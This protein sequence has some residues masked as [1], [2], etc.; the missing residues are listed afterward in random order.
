MISTLVKGLLAAVA[1][2]WLA[3]GL[4]A[5]NRNSALGWAAGR[6]ESA[7]SQVGDVRPPN[8]SPSSNATGAPT[9]VAGTATPAHAKELARLV[10]AT[11]N[12]ASYAP[13]ENIAF[14][15]NWDALTTGEVSYAVVISQSADGRRI[16]GQEGAL[17]ISTGHNYSWNFGV[18]ASDF[19]PGDAEA[20]FSV[21]G[22]EIA[23]VKFAV[24]K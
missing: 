22:V 12:K 16:Y 20:V 6:V 1:V 18:A 13:D 11:A 9:A 5:E 17:S 14:A 4:S 7:V 8:Q 3:G 24:Q 10:S 21:G 19:K 15:L 23:R 2:T